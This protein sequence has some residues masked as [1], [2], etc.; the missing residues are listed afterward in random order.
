[1]RPVA[2]A[3]LVVA[4]A[5][6]VT[7]PA[8]ALAAPASLPSL[9]DDRVASFGGNAAIVVQDGLTGKTLYQ[10]DP[11]APVITASLYKLG[12]LVEAERRVDAGALKYADEITIEPEDITEDGSYELSGTTM[13]IDEALEQMITISDNGAALALERTLGV[14]E[15]NQTLVALKLQPFTL[16]EDPSQDNMASSRAIATLFTQLAQYTLVSKAASDRMLRRLERQKI[17]D[18]L[19]AQL[20]PG[21]IVAHKTGNLGFATHDAGVIYGRAGEPM[22]VVAMTWDSGEEE[23]TQFIQ[24]IGAVVY[25]NALASPTNVAYAL[26]QQPVSV[27]AGRPYVQTV[28]LTNLGPKDWHLAD[29]DPFTLVWDMVDASGNA[30]AHSTRALPLWDVPVGKVVDYPVVI[31][32]PAAPGDYRVTF[33][34]A[35]QTSGALASLGAPTSTLAL[36]ANP[37]L[38]VKLD[39]MISPVLHRNESSVAVVTLSPLDGLVAATPFAMGWRLID[40]SN[41]AVAQ[42]SVP[43]G[44]G[45]PDARSSYLV[46]FPAPG[47]RGPFT[48]EVFAMTESRVASALVRK[49]IEI[50]AAR[51]YPGEPASGFASRPRPRP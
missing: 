38:L 50:D 44:E 13:T 5:V 51:T 23:A 37:P 10:H 41:K 35:N 24:T 16:A 48:L 22:V 45:R 32:V 1:M 31:D 40:R 47:I 49:S 39:V 33:G 11:D 6:P 14:H 36:R 9:L 20:P 42:G 12:V 34:L 21:T 28:R 26:P 46:A 19:P 29:A 18:R 17:N 4:I 25:G 8:R 43:V 7:W 30:V 3:I 2:S 27:A 15:I